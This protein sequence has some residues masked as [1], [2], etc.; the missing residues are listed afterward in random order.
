ML[1]DTHVLVWLTLKPAELSKR[2]SKA[3]QTT[4]EQDRKVFCLSASFWELAIKVSRGRLNLGLPVR[5][6]YELC[7]QA[8]ELDILDT[9]PPHWIQS[10]ELD[11][12]HRD[13]IDRLLVAT[14]RGLDLPLI[15]SDQAIREFYQQCVW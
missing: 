12:N 5:D 13:P 2:A 4:L 6:F 15:T 1:I 3:I 14:A 9:S 10:A 11:W 7:A 8:K